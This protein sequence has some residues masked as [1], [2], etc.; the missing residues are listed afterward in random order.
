MNIIRPS[1]PLK[2]KKINF[3]HLPKAWTKSVEN[4]ENTNYYFFKGLAFFTKE[5][6]L[7]GRYG[8]CEYSQNESVQQ[9]PPYEW[10][11]VFD[12]G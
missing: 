1:N 5:I 4:T 11:P 6:N 7:L 9:K 12:P 10:E 2:N 8:W 3:L